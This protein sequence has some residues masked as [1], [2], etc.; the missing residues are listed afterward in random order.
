[1]HHGPDSKSNNASP[2][3]TGSSVASTSTSTR[4]EEPSHSGA[5]DAPVKPHFTLWQV[6]NVLRCV[7]HFMQ[8]E[9]PLLLKINPD[10]PLILKSFETIFYSRFLIDPYVSI[11]E[12]QGLFRSLPAGITQRDLNLGLGYAYKSVFFNANILNENDIAVLTS[13]RIFY[14]E[15]KEI[16]NEYR[17]KIHQFE[18]LEGK[19]NFK[20]IPVERIINCFL[21]MM[22]QLEKIG[23]AD[24]LYAIHNFLHIGKK[25][26]SAEE[27]K[28]PNTG[29]D[30]AS[31]MIS[32]CLHQ[33][34]MLSSKL[35][36]PSDYAKSDIAF[37]DP[38]SEAMKNE[39][40]FVIYFTHAI[41]TLP[42]FEKIYHPDTYKEW[43][44]PEFEDLFL[45]AK[46]T[47]F[48]FLDTQYMA[49]SKM[50]EKIKKKKPNFSLLNKFRGGEK[51]RSTD[52]SV[53][54]SKVNVS[55]SSIQTDANL[56]EKMDS[57][58]LSDG[59][60]VPPPPIS[61]ASSS[62]LTSKGPIRGRERL[63]ESNDTLRLS[64]AVKVMIP[65]LE[66]NQ[67]MRGDGVDVSPPGRSYLPSLSHQ[68]RRIKERKQT[69]RPVFIP[70][71]DQGAQILVDQA[72]HDPIKDPVDEKGTMPNLS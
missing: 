35:C 19:P 38:L 15:L 12:M 16:L 43:K 29:I 40:Q 39:S 59:T 42:L 45:K 3:N 8:V 71:D 20:V 33:G 26:A 69:P 62:T 22:G 63:A 24:S 52:R 56:S 37:K 1:M 41:L 6:I 31:K 14:E 9:E 11:E 66:M 7:N 49:A 34:F 47:L 13:H 4:A 50:K 58:S 70:A 10:N 17:P 72:T 68:S 28:N 60:S 67:V 36:S 65:L 32:P 5:N 54:L 18:Q 55:S 30:Y 23:Q 48:H 64:G 25:I 53:P 46:V 51:T 27:T 44:Q 61:F 57:L 21:K 2:E